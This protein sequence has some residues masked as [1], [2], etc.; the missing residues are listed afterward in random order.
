MTVETDEVRVL[1]ERFRS[2]AP[3]E[4]R[5]LVRE[6]VRGALE[7]LSGQRSCKNWLRTPVGL[8]ALSGG[9]GLFTA[10]FLLGR[11]IRADTKA[12]LRV[13]G[14]VVIGI[15]AGVGVGRCLAH[16]GTKRSEAISSAG[17]SASLRS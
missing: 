17:H 16:S 10:G 2:R 13:G 9:A 8:L 12:L 7:G 14:V 3:A 6:T 1:L 4:V 15:V 11:A 5:S